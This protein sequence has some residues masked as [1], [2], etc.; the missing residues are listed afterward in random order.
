MALAQPLPHTDVFELVHVGKAKFLIDSA[1]SEAWITRIDAAIAALASHTN[2]SLVRQRPLVRKGSGLRRDESIIYKLIKPPST[3]SVISLLPTPPPDAASPPAIISAKMHENHVAPIVMKPP[4]SSVPDF[5]DELAD[6]LNERFNLSEL[7]S[8]NSGTPHRK[9]T[10]RKVSDGNRRT[11]L[12]RPPPRIA[13]ERPPSSSNDSETDLTLADGGIRRRPTIKPKPK[14]WRNSLRF[15]SPGT[16]PEAPVKMNKSD[17]LITITP[18]QATLH[19]RSITEP[20]SPHS[21]ETYET[22]RTKGESLVSEDGRRPSESSSGRLESFPSI[23]R[24]RTPESI[25]SEPSWDINHSPV[26]LNS[27]KMRTPKTNMPPPP[28]PPPIASHKDWQNGQARLGSSLPKPLTGSKGV[29]APQHESHQSRLKNYLSNART[30]PL[31]MSELEGDMPTYKAPPPKPPKP[32]LAK[33]RSYHNAKVTLASP[34]SKQ[35]IAGPSPTNG[36]I[37]DVR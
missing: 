16:I 6:F 9:G 5:T 10:L 4:L 17:I 1:E 13:E 11:S 26:P 21:I 22:D 33:I 3:E 29:R 31:T 23:D 19:E 2:S 20:P 15:W 36:K 14:G 7:Q 34:C 18:P 12:R 37:D 8:P 32:D 25:A 24:P 35:D 28:P 30:R 27:P